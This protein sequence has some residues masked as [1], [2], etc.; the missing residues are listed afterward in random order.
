M[1]IGPRPQRAALS[2]ATATDLSA[3][4]LQLQV[5][6]EMALERGE[7]HHATKATLG[8][9]DLLGLTKKRLAHEFPELPPLSP[10][11]CRAL[12]DEADAEL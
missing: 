2:E 5:D 4:I 12:R 1:G 11:E 6:R 7:P 9:A 10:D 8:M 3:L